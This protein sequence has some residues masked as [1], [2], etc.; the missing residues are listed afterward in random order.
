MF[1]INMAMLAMLYKPTGIQHSI[2]E[3]YRPDDFRGIKKQPSKSISI[4]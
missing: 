1:H 2:Y 3:I 4:V